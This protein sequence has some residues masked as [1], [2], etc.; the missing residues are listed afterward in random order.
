MKLKTYTKENVDGGL[1]HNEVK[2]SGSVEAF[3]GLV[4]NGNNI[5]VYGKSIISES[6]LDD[7]FAQHDHT[8][9]EN[10]KIKQFQFDENKDFRSVNHKT[11][12]TVCFDKKEIFGTEQSDRALLIKKEY[13]HQDSLIFFI[14]YEYKFDSIGQI[15]EQKKILKWMNEDETIN[16]TIKDKGFQKL[17]KKESRKAV[18]KRRETAIMLLETQIMTL[19]SQSASTEAEYASA[20]ITGANMMSDVSVE[21]NKFKDSGV[22]TK[23]IEKLGT[24][25]GEYT[26][27][28]DEISPGV[29]VIDYIADF[30]NY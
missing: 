28:T 22:E 14:D 1:L 5:S 4:K 10:V 27:L 26:F 9:V 23:L 29:T 25:T 2:S 24:L 12:V 3:R 30:L 19:L 18:M 16:T 21:I 8:K 13:S 20:I 17:S 7:V 15:S 11:E 6:G